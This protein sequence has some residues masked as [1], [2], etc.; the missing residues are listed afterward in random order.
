MS[1]APALRAIRALTSVSAQDALDVLQCLA[2][3][4]PSFDGACLDDCIRILE[5]CVN[6]ESL[7]L[8]DFAQEP[9]SP[10]GEYDAQTVRTSGVPA[11]ILG[12]V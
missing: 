5:E 2:A 1:T 6:E 9:A 4:Q 10:R 12:A 11:W 8:S 7:Q 3:T